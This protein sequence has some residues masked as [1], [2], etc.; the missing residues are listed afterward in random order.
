MT[1]IVFAPKCAVSRIRVAAW[2][3][4]FR[5]PPHRQRRCHDFGFHRVWEIR[6]FRAILSQKS[7]ERA[8]CLTRASLQTRPP[9]RLTK[10][11]RSLISRPNCPRWSGV[12]GGR[13]IWG[14][15]RLILGRPASPDYLNSTGI[16]PG[17]R[18]T[19]READLSTQQT[20]A[21]APSRLPRSS[22]HD[23][24]PQGPRRAPCAWPQAFERL[25]RASRR[26]HYGSAKAAGGL[27]RC[28]RWRAG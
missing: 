1:P 6:D 19:T 12:T 16:L 14:R 8:L 18:R 11:G 4:E 25:S 27:P 28:C 17:Q 2:C 7:P 3:L 26:T 15:V 23:R 9:P 10:T 21:Q 22:G 24:R 20:G 13:L 5:I